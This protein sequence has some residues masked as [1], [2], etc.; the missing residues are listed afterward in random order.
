MPQLAASA[1]G[2]WIRLL[3]TSSVGAEC[4]VGS[5][6]GNPKIP[7]PPGSGPSGGLGILRRGHSR[8]FPNADRSSWKKPVA[9]P[10]ALSGVDVNGTGRVAELI[11]LK[12]A[13][14]KNPRAAWCECFLLLRPLVP[15]CYASSTIERS[16]TLLERLGQAAATAFKR[17]CAGSGVEGVAR[18]RAPGE[19]EFE[20]IVSDDRPLGAGV[21]W[22]MPAGDMLCRRQGT[23]SNQWEVTFLPE[24]VHLDLSVGGDIRAKDLVTELRERIT[25]RSRKSSEAPAASSDRRG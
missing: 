8:F 18:R 1:D 10:A 9:E 12:Q 22:G 14:E 2:L 5:R 6:V 11:R 13:A 21:F 17:N 15:G 7:R 25:R 19:G 24:Q 16:N 20:V 3:V 4:N 23:D